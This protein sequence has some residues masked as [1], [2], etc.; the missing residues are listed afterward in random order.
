MDR[1]SRMYPCFDI[2]GISAER[3]LREW[4]WLAP[5]AFS[6][7][8]VNAFGDLFL[9]DTS[10][11]VHRLDVT[12]GTISVIATSAVEFREAAK[13]TDKKKYWFLE[14]LARQ[15]EGQGYSPRKG[16]CVAGKIPFVFAQSANASDNMYVADIYEYVSFLGDLHS[17]MKDVPNGGQVRIK[18]QPRPVQPN[19]HES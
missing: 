11:S 2:G 12:S 3:L 6:L 8:A 10:G 9:Q 17:Q 15:A 19:P 18:V 16:Q 7:L 5:G 13:D 4:K 14:E 1:E